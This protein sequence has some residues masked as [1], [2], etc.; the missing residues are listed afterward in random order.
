[1]APIPTAAEGADPAAPVSVP[2]P[3]EL[4][5]L[6]GGE[7]AAV[8][9]E[10][11]RTTP[12]AWTPVGYAAPDPSAALAALDPTLPWLGPDAGLPAGEKTPALVLGFGGGT[13][14]G[15]RAAAVER[16]PAARWATIVHAA[17]WVSPSATLGDGAFVGA[18][19]V[20]NAR[21][22]VGGHAIVNS[23][24]V[25][26][27]DVAIGAFTHVAPGAIVGGGARIGVGAFVGLGARVRDHVTVGD[28]A[29][30]AMG[31]VVADDV[32]AGTTVA[33]MPARA[34]GDPG[35]THA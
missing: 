27:H 15:D 24:A 4:V 30:I 2:G 7:H 17:A 10:A 12:A 5:I 28:G 9:L 32:A 13:R 18:G 20:I 26:E 1:M 25:I 33:G 14:P 23:G 8:V 34:A 29:V 6:G 11:A 21:A 35:A 22:V 16:L 31:A 3:R 19:A